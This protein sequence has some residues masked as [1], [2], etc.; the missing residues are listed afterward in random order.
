M[1]SVCCRASRVGVPCLWVAL[2]SA[3]MFALLALVGQLSARAAALGSLPLFV[4]LAV[5][6]AMP[7]SGVFARPLVRARTGRRELALTF[8]DGPD[9]TWTLALLDLL[10]ARRQRATFFVIGNRATQHPELLR[11]MVRRGHEIGNHSWSHSF[12]TVFYSPRFLARE[13][14]R[15]NAT[16]AQATGVRP[17]WFRPPVGLLSPRVPLGT[18][19]AGLTLV[20]WSATARDGVQ[21]TTVARALARLQPAV[22][23]GAILV[24]HDS[25]LTGNGAPIACAVVSRLLDHMEREGLV[26]V[27]LSELFAARAAPSGVALPQQ[28]TRA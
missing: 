4:T 21:R 5:G 22:A 9:P 20:H 26:S 3:L 25:R 6:V 8:D 11:E 19:L 28:V 24:M 18:R 17:I 14:E 10:E 1:E 12:L 27:T 7:A 13:L 2:L 15:T 16:I 23:A